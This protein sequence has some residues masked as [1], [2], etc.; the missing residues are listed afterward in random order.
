MTETLER[1]LPLYE[2]KML[3]AYD[4]RDADVYKSDTA[5][6]RQNQPRYLSDEEKLD[7]TR[8]AMPISWVREEVV[9]SGLKDWLTG[10]SDVTSSTNERTV[11]ASAFPR[12]GVANSYPLFFAENSH[13]L[14]AQWN[15]FVVD[16]LA[17]QKVPGLH[18]N[19]LYLK[20]LA[21]LPPQTFTNLCAWDRARGLEDWFTV[22][23]V[24]LSCTSDAMKPMAQELAGRASVARWD[25]GE[26][27]AIRC[28][29]DAAMFWLFGVVRDDLDYIMETFP[30]V[31]RKD[32]A[33][34]GEF[35]TKR[36]ILEAYDAMQQAIDTGVAY[37]AP[38]DSE[39]PG[40]EDE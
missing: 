40:E 14:L 5:A 19:F 34:F 7:Q 4:H 15:S 13:L 8:E 39:S 26:R 21:I 22:R 29:L 31:K 17:R 18:L 6:K 3:D 23:V 1:M 25:A 20:Q 9:P 37:R 30:I 33:A 36:R 12:A 10:L 28:E 16:Y 35:R 32:Q 2:A 38:W 24:L 27:F 11:L